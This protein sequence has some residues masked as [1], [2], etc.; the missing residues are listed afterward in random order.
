MVVKKKR[1]PKPKRS[2]ASLNNQHAECSFTNAT[3]SEK[4]FKL[5]NLMN[6]MGILLS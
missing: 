4:L 2:K 1:G 6:Y 5:N 3:D